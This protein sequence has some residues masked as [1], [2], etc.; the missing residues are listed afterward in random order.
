[1][2]FYARQGQGLKPGSPLCQFN[3]LITTIHWQDFKDECS[4]LITA[5]EEYLEGMSSYEFQ[6][7][8]ICDTTT[9]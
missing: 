8:E 1:M 5:F 7:L 2:S 3:T 4:I 9:L 6:L